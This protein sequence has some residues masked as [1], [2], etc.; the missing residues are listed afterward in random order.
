MCWLY[1]S[2]TFFRMLVCR[3]NYIFLIEFKAKFVNELLQKRSEIRETKRRVWFKILQKCLEVDAHTLARGLSP[4]N[5]VFRVGKSHIDPPPPSPVWIFLAYSPI[6]WV[7]HR[8]LG[9]SNDYCFLL[10]LWVKVSQGRPC[11]HYT[12]KAERYLLAI[13][14]IYLVCERKPSPLTYLII[15]KPLVYIAILQICYCLSC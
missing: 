11:K 6:Q 10:F 4:I 2:F 14:H 8:L 9:P 7:R 3:A 15:L 13:I 1:L 5:K 12:F